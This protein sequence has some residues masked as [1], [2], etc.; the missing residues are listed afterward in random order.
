MS[1]ARITVTPEHLLRQE[2]LALH[3][4]HVPPSAGM[5][6]LDAMENPYA[7]PQQLRDEIARLAADAAINRYPDAGAHGL[8]EKIRAVT[9]LPQGMEVLLGNGS[10]EIIQLLALAVAKPGATLLSVEPSFVMYKMIATFAGMNYIGVPLTENFAL[11]LPCHVD[12]HPA[13]SACAGIPGL[14]E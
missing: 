2:V 9:G 6:K 12:C 7:L 4:Y 11:D 5:V 8:K 10:D 14:S 1:S 13:P 3:A